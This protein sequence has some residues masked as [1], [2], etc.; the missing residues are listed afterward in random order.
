MRK[1]PNEDATQ[2]FQKY[3]SANAGKIRSKRKALDR[4][5]LIHEFGK[6][7]TYVHPETVEVGENDT[8]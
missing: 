2:Y 6:F 1:I 5:P 4:K 8:V 3:K 7:R